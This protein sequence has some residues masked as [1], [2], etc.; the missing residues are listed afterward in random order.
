MSLSQSQ[1]NTRFQNS[2]DSLTGKEKVLNGFVT[3]GTK[4]IHSNNSH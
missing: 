2:Q 4:N 1:D 3:M